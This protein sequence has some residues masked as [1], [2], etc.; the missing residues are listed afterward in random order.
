[1]AHYPGG[2]YPVKMSHQDK[3]IKMNPFWVT[4]QV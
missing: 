2:D 1:M 3:L 4:E